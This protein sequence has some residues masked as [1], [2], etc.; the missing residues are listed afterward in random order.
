MHRWRECPVHRITS[1]ILDWGFLTIVIT[2]LL[3][4]LLML[5]V[6][7]PHAQTILT[8]AQADHARLGRL[9]KEYD[10]RI[11]NLAERIFPPVL[12]KSSLD[13]DGFMEHSPMPQLSTFLTRFEWDAF[14]ESQPWMKA[15]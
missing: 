10:E 13:K 3:S 7:M 15:E 14:L 5:F 2:G 12:W 8:Q 9:D 1:K 6:W 4:S 11:T